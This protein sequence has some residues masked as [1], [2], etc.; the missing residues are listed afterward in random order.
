METK[1][2]P[3]GSRLAE[4]YPMIAYLRGDV[5]AV[6]SFKKEGVYVLPG[7]IETSAE[8]LVANGFTPKSTMLWPRF[9]IEV[10]T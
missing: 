4:K 9:W 5:M 6:P 1:I 10:R 8:E 3:A 2:V 7:H